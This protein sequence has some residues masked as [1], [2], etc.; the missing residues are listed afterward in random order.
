MKH[1]KFNLRDET[2]EMSDAQNQF[3]HVQQKNLKPTEPK[4]ASK[5]K[6]RSNGDLGWSEVN[7]SNI[8]WP[9]RL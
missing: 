6:A 9:F 4:F 2:D 1:L 7:W 3:I 5:P 8:Q